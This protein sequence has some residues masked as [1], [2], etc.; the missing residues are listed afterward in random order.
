MATEEV[1]HGDIPFPREFEPI[2]GVP[3]VRIEMPVCETGNFC[4]GAEDVLKD[5][6]ED[7]EEGDHEREE[8]QGY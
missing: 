7:E 6:E 1:M 3:P 8:K 2:S 5:Y 4:K